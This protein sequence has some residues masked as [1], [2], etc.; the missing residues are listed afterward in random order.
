MRP[1]F[2]QRNMSSLLLVAVFIGAYVLMG[3]KI[4]TELPRAQG[5]TFGSSRAEPG[6]NKHS[7]DAP[8]EDSADPVEGKTAQSKPA[9]T[10]PAER[11]IDPDAVLGGERSEI[12]RGKMGKTL[13]YTNTSD[14]ER[15]AAEQETVDKD[16]LIKGSEFRSRRDEWRLKQSEKKPGDSL[17]AIEERLKINR[18]NN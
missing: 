16:G 11:K 2:T 17:D 14:E 9:L 7:P 15:A 8:A 12:E 13:G 6:A 5:G 3:G 4:T 10:K 18:A 1:A